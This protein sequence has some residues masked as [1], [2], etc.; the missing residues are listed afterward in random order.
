MVFHSFADLVIL[1]FIIGFSIFLSMPL[2]FYRKMGKKS[3]IGLTSAAAGILIFMMADIFGGVTSAIYPQGSY[4]ANTGLAIL[5]AICA[6]GAFII[7]HLLQ[8]GGKSSTKDSPINISVIVAVAIGFQNLT[9]GMVFG[10][11]WAV[12]I[13]GLIAVIFVGFVLQN[14]TEGFPIIS[15]FLGSKQPKVSVVSSLFLLGAFPTIAGSFV[16]YF[17]NSTYLNIA[18]DALAIGSILYIIMPM[19][20]TVFRNMSGK[21]T[22][23]M[24]YFGLIGGF[25]IGFLVNII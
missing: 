21:G 18:F 1:T 15:P 20:Q 4:V 10:S 5:F 25:I 3:I 11:T 17:Y 19:L 16:G 13:T 6:T 8:T 14:F 2:I 9:E 22:R 7:L 24:A 23:D 12:G